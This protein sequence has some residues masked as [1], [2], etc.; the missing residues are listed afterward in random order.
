LIKFYFIIYPIDVTYVNL[1]SK[2][3]SVTIVHPHSAPIVPGSAISVAATFVIIVPSI[4]A[5]TPPLF[6]DPGITHCSLCTY[7]NEYICHECA[8]ICQK[9]GGNGCYSCCN[10]CDM[11]AYRLCDKCMGEGICQKCHRHFFCGECLTENNGICVECADV[12]ESENQ[13][14]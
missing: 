3:S 14:K 8:I 9:C 7:H 2:K 12:D 5:S 6:D 1:N 13:Y 11:C 4:I 10:A